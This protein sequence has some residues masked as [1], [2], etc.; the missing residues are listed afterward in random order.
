MPTDSQAVTRFQEDRL[1]AIERLQ[2]VQERL[3]AAQNSVTSL[4]T[5]EA[6]IQDEIADIDD[7][8]AAA[9]A[10]P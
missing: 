8:I 10:L 7:A 1:S 9:I 5:T 4:T 6:T 2:K 3:T